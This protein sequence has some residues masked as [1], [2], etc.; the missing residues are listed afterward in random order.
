MLNKTTANK[1]NIT[2]FRF[3]WDAWKG[4][5][6]RKQIPSV[7]IHRKLF[8]NHLKKT[9]KDT[10]G[11]NDLWNRLC[12]VLSKHVLTS[13]MMIYTFSKIKHTRW[14]K[15]FNCYFSSLFL[16][17]NFNFTEEHLVWWWCFP[18][19]VQLSKNKHRLYL[20]RSF[21]WTSSNMIISLNDDT[22]PDSW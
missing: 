12:W 9:L 8:V 22:P 2:F 17:S 10:A 19:L 11:A 1:K 21:R 3:A 6:K 5:N 14:K 15:S 18:Q 16:R 4:K 20:P 13:M 7:I